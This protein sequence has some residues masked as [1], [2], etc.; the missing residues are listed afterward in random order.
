MT[1]QRED[2]ALLRASLRE[3]TGDAEFDDMLRG[4]LYAR[5]ARD[6]AKAR[7]FR[8]ETAPEQVMLDLHLD[9]VGVVRHATSAERLGAFIQR[10]SEATKETAKHLAGANAYSQKLLIEGVGP[11][12]IRV[13]LRVPDLPVDLGKP[14]HPDVSTDSVDSMALRQI[15]AAFTLAS[16]DDAPPGDDDP[17]LGMI[18]HLPA[19]ARSHLRGAAGEAV[20]AGWEIHGT[21]QQRRKPELE[22]L[23]TTRGAGRLR[24][25]LK[26]APSEPSRE[27][28]LG[29]LDGF[30]WSEGI[31]YF[32]PDGASRP[33]AVGLVADD[34]LARVAKLAERR[35]REV[36]AIIETFT[37]ATPGGAAGRTSRVMID[38]SP[39][40]HEAQQPFE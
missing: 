29:T 8:E 36:R 4:S 13:V 34:V 20:R 15:A 35:D 30:R 10:I 39:V 9:G 37:E 33:F 5:I 6:P 17:L 38:V 19:A 3:T 27:T 28:L 16:A 18:Q 23:V 26:F 31:A 25:A 14:A 40:E 7:V 21:V 1:T 12:S 22:M 24:S 11:G 2:L 32:Q